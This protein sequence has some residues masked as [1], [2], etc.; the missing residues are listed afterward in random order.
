MACGHHATFNVNA[1][2]DV[3]V[4]CLATRTTCGHL[5]AKVMPDGRQLRSIPGRSEH[6]AA[7]HQGPN[8]SQ[9]YATLERLGAD[10]ELQAI[11]G[12]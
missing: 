1:R 6:D 8:R 5:A 12:R 2:W 3:V 10:E 11:A 4:S 7:R 9:L